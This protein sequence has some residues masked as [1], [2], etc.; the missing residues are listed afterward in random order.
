MNNID[1]AIEQLLSKGNL[2]I[3]MIELIKMMSDDGNLTKEIKFYS[4]VGD[5]I[6]KK[7]NINNEDK[8][9]FL[10]LHSAL[11]ET[12]NEVYNRN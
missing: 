8:F 6:L 2:Q 12:Y 11:I 5:S 3:T 10:K 4:R 1:K 7:E 9:N